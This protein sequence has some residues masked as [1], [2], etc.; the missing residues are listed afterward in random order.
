MAST[1]S[2]RPGC[3][4]GADHAIRAERP[5]RPLRPAVHAQDDDPA[6]RSGR[7]SGAAAPSQFWALRHV[8]LRVAARRVAG[9]HRPERRRQE[10]AAPG[11]RR[12]HPAV[13]GRGRRPRPRVRAADPRRRLRQG[14]DGSRQHPARRRVPRP[15]RRRHPRAPAVD[16]RVRRARRLHRRAAQDLLVGDARAARVRHRD[17]G[18]PGHPAARR[19]PRHRRRQLPGEVEGARHRD[20]RGGQGGRARHPRHELGDR[21][22]QPGDPHRARRVV[23]EGEPAEVVELHRQ[24][25]EE[26]RARRIAAAE[27]AGVDPGIVKR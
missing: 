19:G 14:A 11:P 27:A 8:V 17:L 24:H 5:R 15:R 3:T 16:H 12:D 10:H 25:T 6:A 1:S 26:A 22:L 4:P 7:C 9:G 21:V 23:I 20:R 13:R 18:R 2:G